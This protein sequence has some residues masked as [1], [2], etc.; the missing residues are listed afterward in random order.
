MNGIQHFLARLF[1]FTS[2]LL[3]AIAVVERFV[4]LFG[5]TMLGSGQYTPGRLLEFAG[6]MLLFVMALL[7]RQVREGLKKTGA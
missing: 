2:F 5:F 1:F 4:N 7:L 6:V 3:L